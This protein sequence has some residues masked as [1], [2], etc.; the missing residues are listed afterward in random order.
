MQSEFKLPISDAAER[1]HDIREEI[2]PGYEA[3]DG[4]LAP[5]QFDLIRQAVPQGVHRLV[6]SNLFCQD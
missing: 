3:D 5:G 6:K 2:V 1:S 4:E